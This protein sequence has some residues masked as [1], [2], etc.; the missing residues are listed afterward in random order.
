[1]IGIADTVGYRGVYPHFAKGSAGGCMSARDYYYASVS[2]AN[3][4]TDVRT[5]WVGRM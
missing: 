5:H 2:A 4:R 3:N 1:M